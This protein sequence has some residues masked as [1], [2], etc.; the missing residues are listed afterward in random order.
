[1]HRP[2]KVDLAKADPTKRIL[3]G[4]PAKNDPAKPIQQNRPNRELFA[5]VQPPR[6]NELRHN[7]AGIT[8]S[9]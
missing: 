2:C 4:A 1:M 9:S 7:L 3:Q 6:Y 5:R 8:V